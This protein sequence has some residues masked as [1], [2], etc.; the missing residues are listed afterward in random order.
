MPIPD[1][2]RHTFKALE[3]STGNITKH[4]ADALND[5]KGDAIHTHLSV[6]PFIDYGWLIYCTGDA[7][8]LAALS[9]LGHRE[10]VHLMERAK[11]LGFTWVKLDCDG[12]ALEGSPTFEW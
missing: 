11:G 8:A 4:T 2:S 12:E 9:M 3:V 6:V 5:E 1:L 10:L 7:G